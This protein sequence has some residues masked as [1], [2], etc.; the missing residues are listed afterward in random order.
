M[1][2]IRSPFRITLGGGGTDIPFYYSKFGGNLITATINKFMYINVKKLILSDDIC[3]KYSESERVNNVEKIRHNVARE[4]L[5]L[6][7]IKKA[8]DI[9]SL[10]DIPA[11]TGLGSSGS[12]G[13]A[14]LKALHVLKKEAISPQDLA[15]EACQIEIDILKK[16]VGKQD[17][18]ATAFGGINYLKIDRSGKVDVYPLNLPL[19]VIKKLENDLLIFFTKIQ[20]KSSRILSLLDKEGSFRYLDKIK[21]IGLES[22]EALK[23]GNTERFGQLLDLHWQTKK[24]LLNVVSNDK[25][26]RWYLLAK[27]NGAV[28]GKIMG[29]GGGGFFLFSC[30][31]NEKKDRLR[32]ALE[33]EGLKELDYRFDFEGVKILANI[34]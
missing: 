22:M 32:S 24:N 10:S 17:Q 31:D 4:S 28:G 8:I 16:K 26:D 5:K 30:P 19:R 27:K 7:G 25:I 12:Y 3:L 34:R 1:I 9:S 6:T 14:L 13:V 18:Y 11:G 33:Q 29:A 23:R 20:R 21:A 2:I 15:E